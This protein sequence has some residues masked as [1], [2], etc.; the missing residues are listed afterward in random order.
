MESS[1]EAALG[2][3]YGADNITIGDDGSITIKE[4]SDA[5][6]RGVLVVDTIANNGG[7]ARKRRQIFGDAQFTDRSGDHVFNNS[8]VLVYPVSMTSYK[9]ADGSFKTEYLQGSEVST[10]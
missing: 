2:F 4:T 9:L 1:S 5:L 10:G 6:P 3:I 8:D 7:T